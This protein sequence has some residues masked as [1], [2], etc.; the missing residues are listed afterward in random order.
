MAF[1][2]TRPYTP[3]VVPEEFPRGWF[4]AD[5]GCAREACTL[6]SWHVNAKRAR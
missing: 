1:H 4:P 5:K 2:D 6:N 3:G